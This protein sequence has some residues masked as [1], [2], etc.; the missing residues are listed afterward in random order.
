V[1]IGAALAAPART[2][3]GRV[4][5]SA[6]HAATEQLVGKLQ[7]VYDEAKAKTGRY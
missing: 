2:G 3:G 6:V 5:R 4:S 7:A 1:V